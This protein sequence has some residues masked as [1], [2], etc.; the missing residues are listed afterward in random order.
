MKNIMEKHPEGW[1]THVHYGQCGQSCPCC[2]FQ[3]EYVQNGGSTLGIC[4]VCLNN[5]TES[6]E[7]KQKRRKM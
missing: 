2:R 3:V 1:N 6:S 4:S 7:P 5:Y